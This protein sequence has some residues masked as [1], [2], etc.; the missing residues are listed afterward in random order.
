MSRGASELR[1]MNNLHWWLE[2]YNSL[3][4]LNAYSNN[5]H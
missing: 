5:L 1:V 2:L 3:L 4:P